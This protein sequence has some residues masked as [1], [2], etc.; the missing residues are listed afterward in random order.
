MG[1]D[2]QISR[3]GCVEPCQEVLPVVMHWAG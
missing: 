2:N 3:L 1:A